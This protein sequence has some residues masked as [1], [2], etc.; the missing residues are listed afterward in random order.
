MVKSGVKTQKSEKDQTEE[1]PKTGVKI[2]EP[3]FKRAEVRSWELAI[4]VSSFRFPI[5]SCLN[6][7]F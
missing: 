5:F 4:E 2:H 7:E 6:P 3:G 1:P